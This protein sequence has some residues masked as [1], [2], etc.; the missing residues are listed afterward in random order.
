MLGALPT[1]IVAFSHYNFGCEVFGS[2][3]QS[4]GSVFHDLGKSHVD[5]L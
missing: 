1:F 4:V 2:A 5:K 3:A